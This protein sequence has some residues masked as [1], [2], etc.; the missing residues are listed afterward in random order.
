MDTPADNLRDPT[1]PAQTRPAVS[2]PA[3][4]IEPERAEPLPPTAPPA[5]TDKRTRISVAWVTA[6]ASAVTLI[7]MLVFILQNQAP[8]T[9]NFA[10]LSGALPL[11]VAMLFAAIAGALLVG[12]L[13]TARITQLR[14]LVR[15]TK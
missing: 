12:F 1:T 10:G 8:V 11:G 3:A 15:R 6:L 4:G 9:V 5:R 7:V 13:G 14:R 2:P